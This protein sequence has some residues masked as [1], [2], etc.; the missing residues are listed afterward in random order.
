MTI[1]QP[2]S[3]SENLISGSAEIVATERR[4]A[5]GTPH[6]PR[7]DRFVVVAVLAFVVGLVGV[8]TLAAARNAPATVVSDTA[9]A[10]MYGP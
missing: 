3:F 5:D 10:A 4:A 9:L 8:L 6:E 1:H 7:A 2:R